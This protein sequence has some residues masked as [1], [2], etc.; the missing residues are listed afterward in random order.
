MKRR[1]ATKQ[2]QASNSNSG[3]RHRCRRRRRPQQPPNVPWVKTVKRRRLHDCKDARSRKRSGKLN[4]QTGPRGPE[5]TQR[6]TGGQY[7][8]A[9]LRMGLWLAASCLCRQKRCCQVGRSRKG[10]G[11][12]RDKSKLA[13]QGNTT[14]AS[15]RV[16]ARRRDKS[17]LARPS[18]RQALSPEWGDREATDRGR[19][20]SKRARS[21]PTNGR[22]L[23]TA[24]WPRH[25]P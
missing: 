23:A 14:A 17:K 18:A 9:E 10:I 13:R 15:T 8:Y 20:T 1:A 19:D 21:A 6:T 11:Q 24:N 2:G 25:Q 5:R 16:Q 3:I 4:T 22:A 7:N 12:G